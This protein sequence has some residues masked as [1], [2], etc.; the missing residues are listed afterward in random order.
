MIT[1]SPF[2]YP[3][4]AMSLI[5]IVACLVIPVDSSAPS[6]AAPRSSND[7]KKDPT[8]KKIAPVA[9]QIRETS[10]PYKK[11]NPPEAPVI[12]LGSSSSRNEPVYITS[13]KLELDAENR[14]F[15]Y[16]GN[17]KVVQADVTITAR[18]MVGRY[19]S[20]NKVETITARK[21]VVVTKSPDT[22][23][24][25]QMGVYDAKTGVVTL[26]ENPHLFQGGNDLAADKITINL[27][28]NKSSAEGQVRMK[29]IKP[30]TGS[31]DSAQ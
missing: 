29:V 9:T 6:L 15:I 4:R 28:T 19:G 30:P 12:D 27:T 18:Q 13:D 25:S 20:D 24:T 10:Q 3:W 5:V 23:A 22:K 7:K 17:V 8:R 26:T 31:T 16:N 21:D 2:D 1:R 11:E 14:S